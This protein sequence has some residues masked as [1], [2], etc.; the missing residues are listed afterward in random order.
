MVLLS[1]KPFGPYSLISRISG[2]QQWFLQSSFSLSTSG[3]QT[4]QGNQEGSSLWEQEWQPGSGLSLPFSYCNL[5]LECQQWVWQRR[6][7]VSRDNCKDSHL[8]WPLIAISPGQQRF[9]SHKMTHAPKLHSKKQQSHQEAQSSASLP[10]K[11]L[12]GESKKI[13]SGFSSVLSVGLDCG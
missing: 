13:L 3:D 9:R 11:N 7:E 12:A 6:A 1:L 8:G 4:P 5:L 10:P 2:R